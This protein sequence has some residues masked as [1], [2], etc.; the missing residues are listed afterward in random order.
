MWPEPRDLAFVVAAAI[1]GLFS[2]VVSLNAKEATLTAIR[3]KWLERL[4]GETAE[5]LALYRKQSD[6]ISNIAD[7]IREKNELDEIGDADG[8]DKKTKEFNDMSLSLSDH[9]AKQRELAYK[10]DIELNEKNKHTRVLL[11][12]VR[13]SVD[14]VVKVLKEESDVADK[15]KSNRVVELSRKHSGR[16]SRIAKSVYKDE[17]DSIKKGEREISFQR[18]VCN[19]VIVLIASLYLAYVLAYYSHQGVDTR[20]SVTLGKAIPT[21]YVEQ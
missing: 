12:A 19:G 7:I 13:H 9:M 21:F 18:R 17:W 14:I 1:A 10:L 3:E 8:V 5:F 2:F 15:E 20:S 11:L 6:F 4:K 16:I